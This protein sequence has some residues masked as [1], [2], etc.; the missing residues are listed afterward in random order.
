MGSRNSNPFLCTNKF[1]DKIIFPL[2]TEENGICI[3]IT[4]A[5]PT[6]L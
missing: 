4:L 5:L 3:N 2:M 6:Y 1:H